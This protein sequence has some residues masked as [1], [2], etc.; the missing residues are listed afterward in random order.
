MTWCWPG[1]RVIVEYDGRHHVE[2]EEQ[3]EADLVRREAIDDS[4]WRILVMIATD[5]YRHPERT[6]RRVHALLRERGL[7]G[8]PAGPLDDW[9]PHFP[10]RV[11]GR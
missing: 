8:L 7:A 1:V 6:V 11:D 5:V 2:R 3:W 4:R 9:R 10:G